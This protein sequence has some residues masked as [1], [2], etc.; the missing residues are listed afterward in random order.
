[1]CEKF[2]ISLI[3]IKLDLVKLLIDK[4]RICNIRKISEHMQASS[5]PFSQ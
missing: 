5:R 4:Y 1:M 2:C 3:F